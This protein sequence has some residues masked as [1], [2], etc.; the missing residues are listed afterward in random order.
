VNGEMKIRY[1]KNIELSETDLDFIVQVAAPMFKDK[2]KLKQ[3]IMEDD[4]FRRGLVLDNRVFKRVM[5]DRQ[6]L[7]RIS[8]ALYF[9]IL[10]RNA[11]MRFENSGYTIERSGS[12]RVAVF[13]TRS[14]SEFLTRY[15]VIYYLADMLSS[16]TKIESSVITVKIRKGV[17]RR[18]RFNDMDIDSLKRFC[19]LVDDEYRFSF[20]KR[21]ADVCLFTL[22]IFYEYVHYN[23]FYSLSGD[24]RSHLAGRARLD[25]QE[26]EEE[27]IKFYRLAAAHPSAGMFKLSDVLWLIQDNFTKSRKSLNFISEYYLYHKKRELFV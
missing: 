20:Y 6:I 10:L 5:S 17:W 8:P 23:Y 24:K 15:P 13:D 19:E 21:I 25:T 7:L 11:A 22:G 26:Y 18:I 4:D 9:E 2:A 3:I 14:L 1:L 27:G 16:F 12:Q